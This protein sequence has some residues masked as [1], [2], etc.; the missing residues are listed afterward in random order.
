MKKALLL[1]NTNKNTIH[2]KVRPNY[3]NARW[4]RV[5]EDYLTRKLDEPDLSAKIYAKEKGLNY[6]SFRRELS[7]AKINPEIN[8]LT[9]KIEKKKVIR[10]KTHIR[11][12]L[13]R[14]TTL[15]ERLTEELHRLTQEETLLIT[16][17]QTL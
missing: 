4:T 14:N 3:N 15:R 13:A 2:F 12:A 10:T 7:Q 9:T 1:S 5:L 16:K 8:H 11:R 17:L 6:N